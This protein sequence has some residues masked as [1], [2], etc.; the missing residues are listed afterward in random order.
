MATTAS[1]VRP[2]AP[3]R[4]WRHPFPLVRGLLVAVLLLAAGAAQAQVPGKPTDVVVKPVARTLDALDA[5]WTAP[6]GTV[7]S[8]D[9]QYKKRADAETEWTDAAT[10]TTATT[11][12][13]TRLDSSTPYVVRVRATNSSGDGAWSDNGSAST[14][15]P[16][17]ELHDTERY[18]RIPRGVKPGQ[19]FRLLTAVGR[20]A[21]TSADV[22]TYHAV[23]RSADNFI[24]SRGDAAALGS[25]EYR[26]EHR[27]LPGA[28]Q[29]AGRRRPRAHRHDLDGGRQGRADL[30]AL[31][32]TN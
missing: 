12:S 20:V 15:P 22:E 26:I 5:S 11:D 21:A 25:Q 24:I 18:Q 4:P 13:L 2:A 10:D 8:Y 28:G 31:F 1:A 16:E 17:E 6:S 3:A 32:G 27:A 14:H 30:L 29:H 19:S 23:A 7:A 9:V